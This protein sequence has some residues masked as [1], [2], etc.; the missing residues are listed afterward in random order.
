MITEP[1][2]KKEKMGIISKTNFESIIKDK[3]SVNLFKDVFVSTPEIISKIQ[4]KILN[5]GIE[6]LDVKCEKYGNYITD[7]NNKS[8]K[9]MFIY[10]NIGVILIG[11]N[12][13]LTTLIIE[14]FINKNNIIK[15]KTSYVVKLKKNKLISYYDPVWVFNFI[16]N[17]G[18]DE[19]ILIPHWFA[20]FLNERD[21]E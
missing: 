15:V 11:V 18:Q 6:K 12:H 1:E 4:E 20:L 5:L 9:N 10:F 17:N 2:C 19:L 16:N 21:Y 14:D 7:S 13:D 3:I 8:N